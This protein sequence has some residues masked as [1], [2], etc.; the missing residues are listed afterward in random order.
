MSSNLLTPEV[1]EG[2]A[3]ALRGLYIRGRK[4]SDTVI[5]RIV[6]T[7]NP[8]IGPTAAKVLMYAAANDV[9]EHV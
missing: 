5:K 4:I 8:K 2:I 1:G 6:M 9:T 7:D 3:D